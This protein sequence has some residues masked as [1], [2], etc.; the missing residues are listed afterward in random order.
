M[1]GGNSTKKLTSEYILEQCQS[2]SNANDY[3]F[4]KVKYVNC[5]TKILLI[6]NSHGEF[7]VSP[8]NIQGCPVCAKLLDGSSKVHLTLEQYKI[9]AEEI[10]KGKYDYSLVDD[11]SKEKI[12]IICPKHGIFIARRSAHIAPKQQY[13]CPKC[14]R[15]YSGFEELIEDFLIDNNIEY[16]YQQTYNELMGGSNQKLPYDFYISSKELLIEYDG[17]HH[18]EP[19]KF[20]KNQSVESQEKKYQQVRKNDGL[21]NQFIFENDLKLLRIKYTRSHD[22][23]KILESEVLGNFVIE[24]RDYDGPLRT[25]LED[26]NGNKSGKLIDYF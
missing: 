23:K 1:R 12:P 13:G 4:S 9:V 18:Y 6:C 17:I 5:R 15:G 19:V 7:L 11:I 20:G 16:E 21:K 10:H 24:D 8:R 14:G 22:I 25:E 2:L 3:D 26:S